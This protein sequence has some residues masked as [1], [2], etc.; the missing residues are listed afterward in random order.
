MNWHSHRQVA[1]GIVAIQ[2]AALTA[3]HVS[4]RVTLPPNMSTDV[5]K[6][7]KRGRKGGVRERSIMQFRTPL[8]TMVTG[9]TQSVRNKMDELE[10]CVRFNSEYRESAVIDVNL[11]AELL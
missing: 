1:A 7:R 2:S 10:A 8:P 4:S 5:P 6:R 11:Q 3:L 9:N